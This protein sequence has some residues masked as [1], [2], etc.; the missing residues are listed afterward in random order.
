MKKITIAKKRPSRAKLIGE[1]GLMKVLLSTGERLLIKAKYD[2]SQKVWWPLVITRLV[3][4]DVTLGGAVVGS[5]PQACGVVVTGKDGTLIN[6][7]HVVK[8][9]QP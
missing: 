4:T 1:P 3:N 2:E 6:L 7:N 5:I 8:F 9:F